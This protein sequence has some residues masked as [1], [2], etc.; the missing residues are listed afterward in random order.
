MLVFLCCL[1]LLLLSG[2]EEG[3]SQREDGSLG[4]DPTNDRGKASNVGLD[5]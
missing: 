2:V 1:L 3:R 4:L 5:S